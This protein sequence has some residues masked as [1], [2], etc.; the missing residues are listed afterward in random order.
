MN[1]WHSHTQ[2]SAIAA[3][4][5][6][7]SHSVP[8]RSG[9]IQHSTR[10]AVSSTF[11]QTL[12]SDSLNDIL[13][14]SPSHHGPHP[15]DSHRRTTVRRTT[16]ILFSSRTFVLIREC[17]LPT[18]PSSS[19]NALIVLLPTRE[20]FNPSATANPHSRLHLFD[21]SI[22]VRAHNT[23]IPGTCWMDSSTIRHTA[24]QSRQRSPS[25]S[26]RSGM[27]IFLSSPPYWAL[28]SRALFPPGSRYHSA[29]RF[30][31]CNSNHTILHRR[32]RGTGIIV[33]QYCTRAQHPEPH[34]FIL[35]Y[36]QK[37]LLRKR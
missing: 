26:S 25:D 6:A 16:I 12:L 19:L 35:D 23:L 13:P 20:T 32:L 17:I 11:L 29:G 4:T 10:T 37:R 28:T 5:T 3:A 14:L 33:R 36:C 22:P 15:K 34:P 27:S 30:R 9:Y 31:I 21:H 18:Y 2:A 7:V 1:Q 8:L 24:G